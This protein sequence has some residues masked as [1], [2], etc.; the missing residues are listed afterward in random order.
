LERDAP[1]GQAPPSTFIALSKE[2]P[3][4]RKGY[5]AFA[6][7]VGT[8]ADG[9][10]LNELFAE[11]NEVAALANEQQ[12]AF[13][14]LFTQ[15][16]TNTVVSTLQALT[17]GEDVFEEA[18]EYGVPQSTRQAFDTI[19]AG[20]TFTW[21]D[22]AWRATW[23][24]LADATDAEIAANASAIIQASQD[25]VFNDVMKT[26]FANTNR[27]VTDKKTGQVYDVFAFANGDGW[28]PPAYAGNT[29]NGTHTHFRTSGAAAIASGDLDEI[30]GDLKSHGYSEENGTQIVVFLNAAEMDVVKTFR[31][32]NGD[33]ADFIP[34]KGQSFF[35]SDGDLIGDQPVASYAGFPVKGGYDGAVLIETSR[36]PAGYVVALASGGKLA[37]T[38]P[39]L[40]RQ[41]PKFPGLTLVKGRDN[42]YPLV[43]SYWTLGYGTGVRHRLA[44]MVMQIT[45][46]ADYA[47]PAQY[48]S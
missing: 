31:T 21:F 35:A 40:L 27:S 36:I 34:S 43:E 10:D 8:T 32:A 48:A 24:Y 44:G 37:L 16:T 4:A 45:A 29:W 41:H 12:Q 7:L 18:S 1:S 19:N 39:I 15:T 22:A 14:D 26:I 25:K 28:V 47:A 38:N 46:D 42:D 11:L 20:A 6:D 5:S 2:K 23:R 3:M 17:S 9:R 13:L 30:I 33:R